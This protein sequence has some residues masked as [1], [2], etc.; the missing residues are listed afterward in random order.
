[1]S[2]WKFNL[3]PAAVP[4]VNTAYR[5]IVTKIPAPGSLEIFHALDAYEAQAMHGQLPVIWDRAEDFR[6]YDPYG[7]CWIDFTSTIFVTNTG[8]ANKAIVEAL[9]RQLSNKLLHTYT[10]ASPVRAQFL[11]KLIEV[12]PRQFEKAFLLSAGTEATECAVKLM[13]MH[14]QSVRLS[15]NAIISFRGSMHGR[16]MGAEMLKGDPKT[17]AWIGYLDPNMHHLPFP[18]P[19][20][21]Q[22]DQGAGNDW[23]VQFSKDMEDLRAGGLDFGNIAGFIVESYLGWG[24]IFYPAAYIQ[25]LTRFARKHKALVT[26]DEIQGGFGRTGKMFVYEHYGVEPDMLCLG[27][28]ISGGLPLSAVVGSKE[29]MDLPEF[30]SMSSTHSANPL[31]CAAGL[32]NLEEIASGNLI[33][34]SARKGLILH[35]RLV[36]LKNKY[37]K[38][39]SHILGKG[40]LAAVLIRNPQNNDPD[41]LF[42]SKVC[43]KA[44]QKGLLLVHTG[45]ESIKIGP[46]LTIPDDALIEGLNVLEESIAE[47]DRE[48]SL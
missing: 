22:D 5:R 46:P 36:E 30:G 43:E 41:G 3:E 2:G 19:W 20:T 45:R 39:I 25:A 14:G 17:S 38:R 18:Y 35:E 1:M 11:K 33:E 16:T 26:F 6:V 44:M 24:A 32:A 31:C 10:F 34:E 37:P 13:R 27:K 9:E 48:E 29:I 28:A 21:V 47:A 7:N 8:H 23:E 12:T 40:L 4:R 15:K 42:A